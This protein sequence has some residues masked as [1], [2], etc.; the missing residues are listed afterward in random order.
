MMNMLSIV[1]FLHVVGMLDLFVAL[2]LDGVAVFRLRRSLS[3]ETMTPWIGLSAGLP[4]LYQVSIALVVLSGAYLTRG[5]V[6]GMTSETPAFDLG[7]LV[8][9]VASLA[10][11]GI[12]GALSIRR[13]RPS[14]RAMATATSG[15]GTQLPASLQEPLLTVLVVLR[16]ALAIAI[17]F[18]MMNRPSLEVSLLV[19]VVAVVVG[20]ASSGIVWRRSQVATAMRG[21]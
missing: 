21:V 9:S 18:L 1:L 2:G 12:T 16:I 20:L 8:V 10:A 5:V 3:D 14:W 4:R 11:L 6:Q 19:M 15:I 7:W 17:V 13:L